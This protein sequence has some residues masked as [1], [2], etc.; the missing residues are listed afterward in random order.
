MVKELRLAHELDIAW[1]IA[2]WLAIH[3]GDPVPIE[4]DEQTAEL[5]VEL[6]N[7]LGRTIGR[8]TEPLTL[9]RFEARL[10]ELGIEFQRQLPPQTR[11]TLSSGD[12]EGPPREPLPYCFTFRGTTYCVRFPRPRFTTH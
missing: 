12:P 5:V 8:G 4:M 1:I 6:T 2:L 10:Q 7:H 3:G 9:E 11:D